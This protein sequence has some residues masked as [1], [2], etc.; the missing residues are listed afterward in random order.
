MMRVLAFA[1]A[2]VLVMLPALADNYLLRV[3]TTMLM[4]S[5]LALGWNFIGG[6][7]GYPSFATA[8]FFGLGAY[9][10]G[11]LQTKGVPMP[12]A[13]A[14]GGAIVAVFAAALGRAILHLRGHYFA[15]ASLVVA[16]VLRE[17]TNSATDLTGGGMGLNLPVLSLD[18]TA[19]ARLFYYAMFVAA[20]AALATTALVAHNRLGFGLRCI[21]QNEDAA[22]MLGINTLRYKVVAFVLSAV[23][24]GVCGGIY[25]SWVNY[26]D[27]TD[28]YDVLLSVKPIVMVLLGGVGTVMGG[29][30]GAV[31]F[32]LMEELVWRNLLQFHAGLLGIIV[33]CLVLFLP[34]RAAWAPDG[35]SCGGG[36]RVAKR[37]HHDRHAA[38]HR[39][40]R[41]FGGLVASTTSRSSCGRVIIVGLIGPER[42]RQ[43]DAGQSI[44]GVHRA[45]AGRSGTG[46]ERDRSPAAG[47]HC[48]AGIARTFQVVASR[49]R[50]M[51]VLE[52]PRAARC[53]PAACRRFAR[54]E[55]RWQCLTFTG[56]SHLPSGRRVPG[57][58]VGEPQAPRTRQEPRHQSAASAAGRGQCRAQC[59]GDR[60][61]ARSDSVPS[62]SAE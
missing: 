35:R 37:W 15:I 18:V 24:P 43:D 44:T 53:L 62:P 40:S 30:F 9:A 21:Q 29:V 61:R 25:A 58:H 41:R 4:Y 23:F 19:Q 57:A 3:A 38:A 56:L 42:R 31:L 39:V 17:I 7:A 47:S 48:P 16:E 13:W 59:G 33:V 52:N 20:A 11:V 5:A 28:V 51:T 36:A 8:A 45:G 55:S 6:F 22:I 26:I 54:P 32:L 1:V 27:P 14:L 60:C 2:V 34:H 12:A 10:S 49:S 46:S 50:L